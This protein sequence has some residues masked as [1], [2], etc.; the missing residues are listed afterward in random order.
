[1]TPGILV[2]TLG[3]TV[4]CGMSFREFILLKRTLDQIERKVIEGDIDAKRAYILVDRVQGTL[5]MQGLYIAFALLS[6]FWPVLWWQSWRNKRRKAMAA[7]S[8]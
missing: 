6:L 4:Y 3:S 7:K 5:S 2:L 1:M 8:L